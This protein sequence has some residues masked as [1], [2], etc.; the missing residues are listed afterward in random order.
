[1]EADIP[2]AFDCEVKVL[3]TGETI[4]VVKNFKIDQV[5]LMEHSI[6]P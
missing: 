2:A 3:G 4:S 5:R 1:M 6:A